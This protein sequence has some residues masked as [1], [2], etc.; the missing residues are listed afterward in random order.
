MLYLYALVDA[1]DG[2]SGDGRIRRTPAGPGQGM[3]GEPLVRVGEGSV[4]ALAGTVDRAPEAC[5]AALRG[6]DA[7][8]R[9]LAEEFRALLPARFGMVLDDE[10]ALRRVLTLRQA[11]LGE[12]LRAV[13]GCAQMTL[14]VFGPPG[15]IRTG[16]EASTGTGY[17]LARAH[18][19]QQDGAPEV[20]ARLRARLQPFV[21]GER[22]ERHGQAPLVAS[23]HHLVPRAQVGAYRR[24]L[25]AAAHDLHPWRLTA[26]GPWAPY[27]FAPE[28]VA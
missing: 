19:R 12:A 17:L 23:V 24:A 16:G 18:A 14:R 5:A 6:H 26:T 20:V 7:V 13:A 3:H 22:T 15:R 8:V 2:R 1:T 4:V 28:A 25:E 9:R 21:H 10:A 11:S 27:A